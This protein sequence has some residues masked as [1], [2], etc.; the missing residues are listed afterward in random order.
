MFYLIAVLVSAPFNLGLFDS[1]LRASFPETPLAQWTFLPAAF[2]PLIGALVATR[3]DS[4][5]TQRTTLLGEHQLSSMLVVLLPL[6]FFAFVGGAGIL[7]PCVALL[8]SIGEEYGWRGYLADALIPLSTSGRYT[9]T[10]LLW[11]PWHLRFET[12]FDW[13]VF[14]VIV[15][16]SCWFLGHAAKESRSVLVAAA[17][18]ASVILLTAS[19]PPSRPM[20]I[21]GALTLAGWIVVGTIF[22]TTKSNAV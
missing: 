1:C 10:A 6:A 20:L 4:V 9:L 13:L 21:A 15:F 22:P 7:L 12:S 3:I 18:H 2:G 8:Y 16:A 19:G 17:M 14:P 5:S 11:W